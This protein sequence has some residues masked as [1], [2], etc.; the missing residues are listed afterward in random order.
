MAT[1]QEHIDNILTQ[2]TDRVNKL[3]KDN[4]TGTITLKIKNGFITYNYT[5][6][7]KVNFGQYGINEN[8]V[9]RNTERKL[10][11]D[12]LTLRKDYMKYWNESG[13]ENIMKA[14]N[15]ESDLS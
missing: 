6:P 12:V 14:L 13:H 2:T 15:F 1:K 3:C 11:K 8:S 10:D 5:E 4:L 9:K 7:P